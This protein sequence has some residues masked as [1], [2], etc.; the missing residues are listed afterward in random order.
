MRILAIDPGFDRMGLAVLEGD[1]S[2]PTHIWSECISP[3][4]GD[5]ADRLAHIHSAVA[6]AIVAHAPDRVAIETLFWSTNNKRSALGVA[7][8]RGAALSAAAEAGLSVSEHS[9]QQ[10]KLA[11]TGYGN[12]DKKAVAQMIPRLISLPEKRRLDDEL[13]AIALCIAAL[14]TRPSS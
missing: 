12:A 9:P 11:V 3:P 2:R 1:P 14:S 4:K 7:E 13:D 5:T 8:A 6:A 10:V